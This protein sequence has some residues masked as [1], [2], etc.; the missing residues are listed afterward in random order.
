MDANFAGEGVFYLVDLIAYNAILRV[1]VDFYEHP[2]ERAG[3]GI[4]Y[5]LY[6]CYFSGDFSTILM[7]KSMEKRNLSEG[8]ARLLRIA[9]LV[10][11]IIEKVLKLF[12]TL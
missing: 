2:A 10:L 9:V 8:L 7:E 5:C 6:A 4:G 3:T 1:L 12:E 11:E